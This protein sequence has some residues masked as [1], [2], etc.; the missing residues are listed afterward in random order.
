M[1]SVR[2]DLSFAREYAT[3]TI[4]PL[5]TEATQRLL[6]ATIELSDADWQQPS[7]L[8]GWTR[9]HIAA[10]LS[11]GAKSLINLIDALLAG[12]ESSDPVSPVLQMLQ[13]ER[14]SEV[15]ALQLQVALDTTAGELREVFNKKLTSVYDSVC[16]LPSG[17]AVPSWAL[18]L[19]RL[20]EVIIHHVD[21]N[22]GFEIDQLDNRCAS[23]LLN[24]ICF[25]I[26]DSPEFPL[27]DIQADSGYTALIG[28]NQTAG[29]S[30]DAEPQIIY[31]PDCQIYGWLTGRVKAPANESMAAVTLP[32]NRIH[33]A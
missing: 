16:K 17:L 6:G 30:S 27:L 13:L 29:G 20:H 14:A 15:S 2:P 18:P 19:L 28:A 31:G 1:S 25:L 3:K 5:K 4:W 21:L 11:L 32:N 23:I 10:H 9:A 8:P 33:L 7:N 22:V 24:W 26:A 12:K